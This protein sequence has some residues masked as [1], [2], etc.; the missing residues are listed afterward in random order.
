[1]DSFGEDLEAL[2]E[3]KSALVEQKS[4]FFGFRPSVAMPGSLDTDANLV[5]CNKA[6][7]V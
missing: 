4:T 1:L 6:D 7:G 3:Q 2:V 5:L